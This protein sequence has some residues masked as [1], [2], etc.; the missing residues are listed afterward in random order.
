MKGRVLNKLIKSESG[1]SLVEILVVLAILA[2]I[3][4]GATVYLFG[5][6]ERQ[7]PKIT[8]QRI[9]EIE[10]Y[11]MSFK[12]DQGFLPNELQ[13]LVRA[14]TSG[15]DVKNYPEE[16]YMD[17][18]LLND[19]WDNPFVYHL[20]GNR[21]EIISYGAD[22]IEGGEGLDEDISSRGKKSEDN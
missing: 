16:G 19:A 7:K 15:R 10:K 12:M 9:Q 17:E 2:L 20:E 21:Y 5:V 4:G 8:T 13:D 3:G 6:F 22:G 11:I 14:P 1:L 18:D